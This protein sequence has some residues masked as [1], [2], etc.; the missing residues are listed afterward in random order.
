[1]SR[2]FYIVILDSSSGVSGE[3]F[4]NETITRGALHRSTAHD[5][6]TSWNITMLHVFYHIV[7]LAGLRCGKGIQIV[8]IASYQTSLFQD[9]TI[10]S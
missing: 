4:L 5:V 7:E 6:S 2:D 10:V 9:N 3:V 8:V 1:M